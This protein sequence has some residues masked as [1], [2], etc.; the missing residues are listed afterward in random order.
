MPTISQVLSFRLAL[1][2]ALIASFAAAPA[3]HASKTQESIFQDDTVLLTGTPGPT[4]DQMKGLGVNTIHTLVYWNRFGPNAASKKRPSG[5]LSNPNSYPATVWAPYDALVKEATA[6]G[7]SILMTPTGFTPRWA[8]LCKSVGKLRNCNPDPKAFGKFVTAVARRY[9]GSFSVNGALLPRVKRW[10]LWNEPDQT[11]WIAPQATKGVETSPQI[12][13]NLVYSGLAALKSTGHGKD[14]A[15]LGELAPAHRGTSTDPTSFLLNLFCIDA[16]GHK[17]KGKE[18]TQQGC[19]HFKKFTAITG[20]AHHPY[21]LGAVGPALKKPR[22]KGDISLYNI[23]ALPAILKLAA[24][25][26]AIRSNLPIFF[27]EYGIQTNPPI[28]G[29][30]TPSAQAVAINQMDFLAWQNPLVKSVAQYELVDAGVVVPPVFNTGLV[31]K[32]GT[33]KV[34][35]D[36]YRLPIWVVK[37][38]SSVTLWAWVRPANGASQQVQV[39]HNTGAGFTTV[40][41]RLTDARGFINVSQ[42]GSGGTWRIAWTAPLA[43]G[44]V[45]GSLPVTYFSRAAAATSK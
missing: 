19:Q 6:R 43:P 35:L 1:A 30:I 33:P 15:L 29:Q 9:S 39:Q 23:K 44:A 13:R 38:G 36:A 37:H 21:N 14:Q 25:A 24:K 31:F 4:L 41:T 20:F 11:G 8:E 32:N 5:D 7:M 18:R 22:F 12:Y 17:L 3:A 28:R 2:A 26:H 40:A 34:S 42:A 16:K 45:P 27:T 10:S